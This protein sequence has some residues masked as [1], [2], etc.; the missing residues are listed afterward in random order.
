M[1]PRRTNVRTMM[2][3]HQ[4]SSWQTLAIFTLLTIL[5]SSTLSLLLCPFIQL[6]WWKIF[7]R[8]A[9]ISAAISLLIITWGIEK[10]PVR[11][12]GL[13]SLREG[14][15]QLWFGI[16]LGLATLV[17]MVSLG[18][19]VGA[20]RISVT[21]SPWKFWGTLI[22]T[23]PAMVL[24]GILEE[25]IFRGLILQR[26]MVYSKTFAVVASSVVYALVHLKTLAPTWGPLGPWFELI[27][28]FLFGNILCVSYLLTQQLYLAIGLHATLAYGVRVNKLLIEFPRPSLNW[29]IGTNRLVNG[30]INWA[31]LLVMCGVMVLWIKSSR[32]HRRVG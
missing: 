18:L 25:L 30:V 3:S 31:A 26:L 4:L 1:A 15:K 24:V 9:S 13:G 11:E 2:R 27:G 29:L 14:R 6:P 19:W 12:F 23:M 32:K 17:V 28:L 10:R 16:R 5:L 20:Y 21:A 7:R 8:C 22:G